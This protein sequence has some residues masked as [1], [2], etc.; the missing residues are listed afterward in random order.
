METCM[1]L[2]GGIRGCESSHMGKAH[3]SL[4]VV[5]SLESHWLWAAVRGSEPGTLKGSVQ[6]RQKDQ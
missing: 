3:F 2:L 6:Y 1:Y 4:D 5:A